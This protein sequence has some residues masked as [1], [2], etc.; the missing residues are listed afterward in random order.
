ML[1]R[2]SRGRLIKLMLGFNH[3]LAAHPDSWFQTDFCPAV[4]VTSSSTQKLYSKPQSVITRIPVLTF[5]SSRPARLTLRT[6]VPFRGA[7]HCK[8]ASVRRGETPMRPAALVLL[9]DDCLF[10]SACVSNCVSPHGHVILYS[11]VSIYVFVIFLNY[12]HI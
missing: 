2:V 11:V 9:W 12:V 5:N 1:R 3:T 6:I 8:R 4:C 10:F 7:S